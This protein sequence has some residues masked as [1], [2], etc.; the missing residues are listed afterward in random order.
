M[1]DV[2][3]PDLIYMEVS[4]RYVYCLDSE[5]GQTNTVAE[6][7]GSFSLSISTYLTYLGRDGSGRGEGG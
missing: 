2:F 1:M 7:G 5:I 4:S 3:H 6:I